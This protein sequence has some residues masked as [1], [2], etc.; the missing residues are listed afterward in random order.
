[1]FDYTL[2]FVDF[3]KENNLNLRLSFGMP[4]GYET[5]NGMF[6]VEAKTI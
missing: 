2:H 5:A 3:C 1:M 4:P 6:D